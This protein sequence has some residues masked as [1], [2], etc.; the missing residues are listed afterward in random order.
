MW[1]FTAR[2][3]KHQIDGNVFEPMAYEG[4][5]WTSKLSRN[6]IDYID[7]FSLGA[8]DVFVC[9]GYTMCITLLYTI[10]YDRFYIAIDLMVFQ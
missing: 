7:V 6:H 2:L 9:R 8:R 1:K 3:P 5:N 10:L 4:Y